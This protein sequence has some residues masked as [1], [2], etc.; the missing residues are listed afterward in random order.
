[1]DRNAITQKIISA[2]VRKGLK[3]G[4]IAVKLSH[5]K[6]WTAAACLGQMTFTKA[7]VE[8]A[9]GLFDLSDEEAAWLQIPPLQGLAADLGADRSA[10]LSLV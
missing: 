3:W 9:Q 2:K 10:D 1:M 6:E 4:D 8:V 5:S 7:Q